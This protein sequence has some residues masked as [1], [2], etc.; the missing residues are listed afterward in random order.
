[1][2]E[3][4]RPECKV[5]DLACNGLIEGLEDRASDHQRFVAAHGDHERTVGWG[6]QSEI[7][8]DIERPERC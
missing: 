8:L 1:L 3:K 7:T 4:V 5:V 6:A 2:P